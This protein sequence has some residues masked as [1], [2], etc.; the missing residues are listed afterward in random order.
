MIN[1]YFTE[2]MYK[3]YVRAL[4]WL[5]ENSKDKQL[6]KEKKKELKELMEEYENG[7]RKGNKK[8]KCL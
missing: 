8:E 3:D 4:E 7:K 5:I 6:V 1:K 2:Q